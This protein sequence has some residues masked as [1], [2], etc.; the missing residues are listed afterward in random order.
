MTIESEYVWSGGSLTSKD[1]CIMCSAGYY[2]ESTKANC[3]TTWG[4]GLRSGSEAWDDNN[5][6]NGDGCLSDCT[7]IE[8]GWIWTGGSTTSQD[9]CTQ[10]TSGFYPN[11]S[12]NQWVTIC[13]DGHKAGTEVWDDGNTLNGDGW[14]KN[15]LSIE[16]GW[17]CS[18][19]NLISKDSCT[20][21]LKGF[22]QN[23]KTN[24]T[25]WITIWGDG[26]RQGNEHWD[27]GN[28]I[29]GDGWSSDCMLIESG[30]AWY[31]GY[32]GVTDVWVQWDLGYDPNPDYSTCIG[33]ET[34]RDIK[35]LSAS[36]ALSAYLGISSN[37]ILTIFSSS[38]SSS[39]SS[40]SFGMIN[41][42]QLVIIFPLIG[43]YLPEKIY[44]YLK[45]MSTCLFNL[46]FLPTSNSENTVSFKSLFDYKQQNS[47]LYLLQLE[48]E[49]AFVNIL[50]LT[51]TVGFAIGFH[52]ILLIIYAILHKLNKLLW[53]KKI[54]LKVIE[55]LSFGFYIGVCLETYLLFCL[56]EFSEIHYQNKNGI[57]NLK[58]TIMSYVIL[59][60]MLL[61]IL[62]TLWQW[63]KSKTAEGLEKL[64]YFKLL[65][66]DMKPKWIWGTY[67]LIFLLRRTVLLAIIFF[68]DELVMIGKVILF[69]VIQIAYFAYI[70]VLR[71]QAGFKEN[72]I[73]FINE[74]FYTYFVGFLLYF[75]SKDRWNDTVTDVY[76]WVMMSNNF[77]L[78]FVLLRKFK[79]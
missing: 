5:S 32:F 34:S 40:N 55:M 6:N 65:V 42:I 11:I 50:D 47:Y 77:I 30:W 35:A 66:D 8:F 7:L 74:A 27:D 48:S 14:S 17:V 24:P 38:S 57:K 53:L 62:L 16:S 79:K 69:L 28:I 41:Q 10:C 23:D 46:N 29:S 2:P 18:G 54:I 20:Q 22:Y 39:S 70:A 76:F 56:V 9:T 21:C 58:S 72:L 37:L 19:G 4:D 59:A 13:G 64:K 78:M 73:D 52:V 67:W 33:A 49:S 12:N 71:P 43:P 51:T 45:S 15:W 31:G 44:D 1:I 61:F 26:I 25:K 3:I 60:F 68:F 63:W 36:A 75:N